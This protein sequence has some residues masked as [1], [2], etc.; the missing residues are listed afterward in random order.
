MAQ[1]N[2][3]TQP[4]SKPLCA[5]NL[6][7]GQGPFSN[8]WG[9]VRLTNDFAAPSYFLI[10]TKGRRPSPRLTGRDFQII[11]YVSSVAC[12]LRNVFAG[13]NLTDISPFANRKALLNKNTFLRQSD[14]YYRTAPFGFVG[15]VRNYAFLA[16]E[17]AGLAVVARRGGLNLA[18]VTAA[19][20][21]AERE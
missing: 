5:E 20:D 10:A 8:T 7:T 11:S 16:G 12:L 15:F 1:P 18:G 14:R 9:L 21:R 4:G 6:R 2:Y 17:E 3:R 13:L 19:S